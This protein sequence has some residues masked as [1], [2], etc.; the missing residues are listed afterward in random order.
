MS[1]R[2][3]TIFKQISYMQKKQK[4]KNKKFAQNIKITWKIQTKKANISTNTQIINKIITVGALQTST[5][6][7]KNF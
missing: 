1:T 2:H 7:P 4:I 5:D 3:Q 6:A